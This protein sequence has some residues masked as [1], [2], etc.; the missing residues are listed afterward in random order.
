MSTSGIV[1]HYIRCGYQ[2][3]NPQEIHYFKYE[4]C[5][6]FARRFQE[7]NPSVKQELPVYSNQLKFFSILTAKSFMQC[8]M[9]KLCEKFFIDATGGI[10]FT[11]L[12]FN[13]SLLAF[14]IISL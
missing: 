8:V 9:T 2:S 14:S 5:I 11:F 6:R 1:I 4:F 13:S 3:P 12:S 10:L 7:R